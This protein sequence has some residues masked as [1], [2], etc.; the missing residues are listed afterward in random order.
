M[1]YLVLVEN[2]VSAWEDETGIKYHFPK[3]Y[4]NL[5]SAGSEFVYYKG[6]L[7]DKS[8][9][10][11]RL[12]AQPH[13]FGKGRLGKIYPDKRSDKGDLFAAIEDFEMFSEPVEFKR[14][15]VYLEAQDI[16][17]PNHFRDAIRPISKETF[18][19]IVS[20]VSSKP[21][22]KKSAKNEDLNDISQGLESNEE[23]G[24]KKR[25]VT[26][27]ERSNHNRSLA[28]AIHGENCAA[29][30]FNFGAFYGDYAEG[31]IQVH[32]VVPVSE[33]DGPIKPDPEK[34]LIPLCANCHAVVHRKRSKTLSLD[35]LKGL[36]SNDQSDFELNSDE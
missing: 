19:L 30:G 31:Y 35:E 22:S 3:K 13:Y 29:C 6:R 9:K 12:S 16:K 4:N 18:E 27:Y 17:K 2:D 7:Q 34:D 23:G 26:Q 10:D 25:Y 28:I 24:S 8:F 36:I 20:G 32:H 1:G 33:L 5:V 14:N 11:Q 15:D 21:T